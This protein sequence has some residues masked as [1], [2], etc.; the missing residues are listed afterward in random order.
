MCRTTG[1]YLAPATGAAVLEVGMVNGIAPLIS[2][3][4]A[5]RMAELPYLSRAMD[6]RGALSMSSETRLIVNHYIAFPSG[7][8]VGSSRPS[9]WTSGVFWFGV[10]LSGCVQHPAAY[11]GG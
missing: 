7:R 9:T 6:C 5:G 2:A 4:R 10:R 11:L 1:R 8:R 3:L